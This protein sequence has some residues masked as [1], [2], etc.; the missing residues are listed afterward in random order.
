MYGKRVAKELKKTMPA[1][2]V[3]LIDI[4]SLRHYGDGMTEKEIEELL[5]NYS[6]EDWGAELAY[7]QTIEKKAKKL[8]QEIM[9]END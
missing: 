6:E 7:F 3:I 1:D 2:P 9:D 5:N 4:V 8:Y